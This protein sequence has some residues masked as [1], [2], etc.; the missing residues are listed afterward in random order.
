MSPVCAARFGNRVPPVLS[1]DPS[2]SL[3]QQRQFQAAILP[4]VSRTFAL[5]IPALPERLALVVTNAYLLCRIADTIEDDPLLSFDQK[6]Q[7][8]ERFRAT[9]N[10]RE[11]AGAFANEVAPLLSP[12]ISSAE[13]ELIRKADRV[14]RVTHS[15]RQEER[16]TLERC[17]TV[18]CVDMPKFQRNSSLA[19]LRDLSEL[20]AYCYAVAGVAGEMLVD[21]FCIQCPELDNNRPALR[22]LAVSFGQGLQM[23]N[24]LKDIW[25]DHERGACWLPRTVFGDCELALVNLRQTHQTEEFQRGLRTLIGIAHGHLRNA[26][27]F[28]CQ[29]PVREPGMR[30]FCLWALGMALLTLRKIQRHPRFTSSDQVKISRNSVRATLLTTNLLLRSNSGLRWLFRRAAAGLPVAPG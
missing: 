19:G 9:V 10:G 14:V 11:S 24:I 5:T 29:L 28:S 27:E 22:S 4:G 8:L 25:A 3:E 21:L 12:D 15:F 6:Q 17:V 16:E 7:L 23:T 2:A 20:D 30:R 26:M 18:M 1:K 13:R